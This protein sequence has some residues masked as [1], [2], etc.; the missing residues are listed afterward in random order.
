MK[1]NANEN[2]G[3]QFK[4]FA[5]LG[6]SG[7][8]KTFISRTLAKKDNWRHYSVDYEIG[9]ILSIKSPNTVEL[10]KLTVFVLGSTVP[11]ITCALEM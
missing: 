5:L 10:P 8:G 3:F 7:L 11:A 6:M 2:P 1:I 9:K 4:R